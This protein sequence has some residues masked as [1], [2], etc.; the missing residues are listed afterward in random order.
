MDSFT[1]DFSRDSMFKIATTDKRRNHEPSD[2]SS[3]EKKGAGSTDDKIIS[4]NSDTATATPIENDNSIS[5]A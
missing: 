1:N 2:D 5:V 4:S 3:S